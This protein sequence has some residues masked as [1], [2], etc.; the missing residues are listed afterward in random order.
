MTTEVIELLK[1]R[2]K[3]IAPY[4]NMPFTNGQIL[5]F[6]ITNNGDWIYEW[7]EHDGKYKMG[8][9]EFNEYPHLFKRLEWWE[10]RDWSEL[11]QVQYVKTHGG[12]SVR[13]VKEIQTRLEKIVL[14]D[15][16]VKSIKHWIPATQ[17][18]Y[19]SFINQNKQS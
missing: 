4:P 6:K 5:D 16:K 17:S 7:Y 2:I 3:V 13:T 19:E 9:L 8:L 10:E 15:G 14:D 11:E 12:N 18:E 1:P